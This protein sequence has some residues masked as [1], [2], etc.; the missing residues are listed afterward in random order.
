M[1]HFEPA[2]IRMNV[3]SL[4]LTVEK[5]ILCRRLQFVAGVLLFFQLPLKIASIVRIIQMRAKVF[6]GR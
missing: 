2:T 1:H 6:A 3:L 5:K 4:T